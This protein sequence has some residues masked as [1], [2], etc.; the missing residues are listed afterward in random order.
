LRTPPQAGQSGTSKRE[1]SA[2]TC[3]SPSG[4]AGAPAR[5]AVSRAVAKAA[6]ADG[7]LDVVAA[8]KDDATAA[9]AP[10]SA[11]FFIGLNVQR[12]PFDD[13]KVRLAFARALDRSAYV[14]DVLDLPG[15]PAASLVPAGLPGADPS[16]DTQ[17][18]DPVAARGLLAASEYQSP[19]PPMEFSYRTN[20]PRAIAEAKWAIQQWKTNLGVTVAE[21]PLGPSAVDTFTGEQCP[22]HIVALGSC[23]V[24]AS[25]ELSDVLGSH[26][27]GDA[28]DVSK[29]EPLEIDKRPQR[30]SGVVDP[31]S[32]R[33]GKLLG[34]VLMTQPIEP[35]H[36]IDAVP[37]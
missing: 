30:D 6:F 15:E 9:R 25:V 29:P 11:T 5:V 21:H 33:V 7:E 20:A 23:L 34:E 19:L 28:V 3:A 8:G 14:R 10:A 26:K 16:D 18:F 24:V 27:T 1:K 2:S 35:Q 31:V 17:A 37:A 22:H 12:P 32:E 4:R 36:H 13:P